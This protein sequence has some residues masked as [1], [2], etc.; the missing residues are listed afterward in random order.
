MCWVRWCLV[1]CF[2]LDRRTVSQSRGGC[3]M[4]RKTFGSG[5]NSEKHFGKV[6]LGSKLWG[7]TSIHFATRKTSKKTSKTNE[8]KELQGDRRG[9]SLWAPWTGLHYFGQAHCVLGSVNISRVAPAEMQL[10]CVSTSP[11]HFNAKYK[12][13]RK[14]EGNSRVNTPACCRHVLLIAS[15]PRC[16]LKAA[17][18]HQ[19]NASLLV[20]AG[21]SF[22]V[23]HTSELLHGVPSG[24]FWI[25][26]YLFFER[27]K[28]R[29]KQ[30]HFYRRRSGAAVLQPC[31]TVLQPART[32][33]FDLA[34]R[35]HVTMLRIDEIILTPDE[36]HGWACFGFEW[37]WMNESNSEISNS[38]QKTWT[39]FSGPASAAGFQDPA[40]P[41][42]PK[43]ARLL[44]LWAN[45]QDA[46]HCYPRLSAVSAVLWFGDKIW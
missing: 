8:P 35:Q 29:R 13:L 22:L 4:D 44:D 10:G 30:S 39:L 32:C 6:A 28:P 2:W 42:P 16:V 33:T 23:V 11:K 38:T 36:E 21:I 37:F 7:T 41:P 45:R 17:D 14:S 12:A 24:I 46:I 40:D 43:P 3:K 27:Y 26:F 34:C 15:L 19:R 25:L 18:P 31:C 9:S 20:P 1:R 5:R